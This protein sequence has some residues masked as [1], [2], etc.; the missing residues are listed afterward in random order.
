ML[1]LEIQYHTDIIQIQTREGPT[2]LE[3]GEGAI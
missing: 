3:F 1:L 2:K